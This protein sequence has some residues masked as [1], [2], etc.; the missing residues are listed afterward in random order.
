MKLT[1]AQL[2]AII[3]EEV[4]AAIEEGL[5][6]ALGGAA[7]GLASIGRQA[8]GAVGRAASAAGEKAYGALERGISAGERGLDVVGKGLGAAAEK[9]G[10]AGGEVLDSAAMGSLKADVAK[11]VKMATATTRELTG[12]ASRAK[13]NEQFA[14]L[15]A[16]FAAE[17]GSLARD[18]RDAKK[19]A[20]GMSKFVREKGSTADIQEQIVESIVR[21]IAKESK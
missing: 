10:K 5:F 4:Q 19:Q 13:G 2:K 14:A 11:T 21:R 20:R 15:L 7:K 3:A 12:Y 9:V 17:L 16:D 18:A 8:A 1:E 6:G